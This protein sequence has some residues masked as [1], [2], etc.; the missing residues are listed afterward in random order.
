M[1][2]V[3]A[4]RDLVLSDDLGGSV[5]P[6]DDPRRDRKRDNTRPENR[7]E[8]RCRDK[9]D[10]VLGDDRAVHQLVT[11]L[12]SV[13]RYPMNSPSTVTPLAKTTG[14]LDR[15]STRLNSSHLGI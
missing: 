14:C 4:G 11:V 12:E 9:A 15:K 5:R 2:D 7:H 10:V 3:N 13:R 8:A 6:D 1:R